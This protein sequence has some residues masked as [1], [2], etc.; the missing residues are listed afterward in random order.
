MLILGLETSCD[1][2]AAAVLHL[3]QPPEVVADA[4]EPGPNVEILAN[5]VQSQAEVH[6]PYGGVVPE[7]ASRRHL[8]NIHPVTATALARAGVQ[9]NQIDLLA[10]TQGPGLVGSLLVGLN[11]AK[12]LSLVSNI[13]CVGVDHIAGHLA[14]TFLSHPRPSFPYLALTVSGG[15]SNIFVVDDSTRFT[16]HGRTRDDA[17]GEAFDKVAKLLKLGYPGGPAVSRLAAQGDPRAFAFPRARLGESFDFSFSGL[18][19]AVA[20]QV[21]RQTEWSEQGRADIC[22]SFQEAVVEILVEKTLA[23]ARHFACRQVVLSGGVAANPRLRQQLVAVAKQEGDLEV[24]LP[25]P[26]FCTD[27]AAMIAMAGFFNR[28]RA[29]RP[30]AMD[31]YSRFSTAAASAA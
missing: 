14:S 13:P 26:I 20:N 18:K 31:V 30:L 24:F 23:A 5:L 9:L 7:L 21:H 15:H 17:A 11:F 8:E 22:A 28:H 3:K 29:G 6:T 1:D 16:L 25:E 27:N 4:G 12:A 10:V 2:T 19:T